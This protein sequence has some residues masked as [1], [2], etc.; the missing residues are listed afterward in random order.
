MPATALTQL[1]TSTLRREFTQLGYTSA[2]GLPSLRQRIARY[3]RDTHRHDVDPDRIVITTGSSNAFILAFLTM[4]EPGDRVA[5][6][7]P[8]YPPYRHILTALG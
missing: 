6:T 8:G 1:L 7:L 4:F 3:Y 5:V 2:L